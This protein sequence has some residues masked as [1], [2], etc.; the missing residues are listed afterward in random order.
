MPARAGGVKGPTA[1]ETAP[2]SAEKK[3]SKKPIKAI[4]EKSIAAKEA[5]KAKEVAAKASHAERKD[6][7]K[8]AG[9]NARKINYTEDRLTKA[10]GQGRA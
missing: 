1:R 10:E 3:V 9:S 6:E 2:K 8:G 4:K 7:Y 5:A